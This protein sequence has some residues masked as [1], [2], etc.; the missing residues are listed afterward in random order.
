M[1]Y[2]S[3]YA[4]IEDINGTDVSGFSGPSVPAGWETKI[5]HGSITFWTQRFGILIDQFGIPWTVN[6]AQAPDAPV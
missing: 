1:G 2:L 3:L 6:C 5:M 4:S